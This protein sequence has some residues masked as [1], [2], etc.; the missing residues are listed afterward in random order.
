[1]YA[2]EAVSDLIEL[3]ERE[4]GRL[5]ALARSRHIEGHRLYGDTQ[6]MEWPDDRLR[7]ERDEEVADWIVYRCEELRRDASDSF[8]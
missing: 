8:A 4:E 6:M 5:V 7:V 1:M 2:R 3:L